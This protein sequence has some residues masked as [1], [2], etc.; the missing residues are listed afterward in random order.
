MSWPPDSRIPEQ[1]S[2]YAAVVPPPGPGGILLAGAKIVHVEVA[3]L[4]SVRTSRLRRHVCLR[5]HLSPLHPLRETIERVGRAHGPPGHGP[6]ARLAADHFA[7][8]RAAIFASVGSPLEA[9][10]IPRLDGYL[11][12]GE[13]IRRAHRTDHQGTAQS[14]SRQRRTRH[15]SRRPPEI[16]LRAQHGQA[17]RGDSGPALRDRFGADFRQR[18]DLRV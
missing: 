12:Q 8:A 15:D 16:C 7:P 18:R 10:A 14:A 2:G 4:L 3:Q 11:S 13:N 9:L 17:S 1:I 6:L 5:V